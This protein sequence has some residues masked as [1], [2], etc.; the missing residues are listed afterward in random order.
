MEN[1]LSNEF[2]DHQR[3]AAPRLSVFNHKGGVGKTTLTV[4]LAFAIA[5]RGFRVLLVDSDPQC[6]L[7]SYLVEEA[8]VDD[9][10][11]H[12]DSVDGATLWSAL[13]PIAEGTGDVTLISP[14]EV[15]KGL[16]LL[17]GD[18]RL[19]EFEGELAP[20]WNECFQR[21]VKG[22]RGTGALSGLVNSV[23]KENDIDLIIYDSGPNIGPL[24]RV[25]LLDC[26]FFIIP[27][28]CDFFSLRAIRT[29]GRALSEWIGNWQTIQELAP[30]HVYLLPGS[31]KLLGYVPQRFR[32]YASR[33]TAQFAALL[34]RI[35]KTVK[36]DVITV[37]SRIDASLV[38]AA[39]HPL[40]LAEI[41]DYSGQASAAQQL[42][43]ALWKVDSV[44]P[45][46]QDEAKQVFEAFAKT[47][48]KRM[49]ME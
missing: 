16:F 1:E 19:A 28:A 17:P 15:G 13:K 11:D 49:K 37:L 27:A 39:V 22:F 3:T 47:V 26:D 8:V 10:L 9:L 34:P 32:V 29:L 48:L 12:S 42:G 43:V 4:N 44:A 21:K 6:N 2:S 24:N 5:E 45:Q 38:A 23:A 40:N 18:I 46:Q 7:T 20:F 36:E 35:E 25:I 41:K 30:D 33:P 14:I 31:P